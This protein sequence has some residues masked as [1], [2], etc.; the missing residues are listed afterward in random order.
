MARKNKNLVHLRNIMDSYEQFAIDEELNAEAYSMN[1]YVNSNIDPSEAEKKANN[2]YI[3]QLDNGIKGTIP[4]LFAEAVYLLDGRPLR[5]RN[6]DYLKIIYDTDI[7]NMLLMCGRQVEKS[8]TASVHIANDTLLVPFFRTLY[9]APLNEQVKVF[10]EDRLGRLFTY[11]QD[12]VIKRTFLTTHDKQNVFN[13]SFAN[14][15]IV[16][17]RHCYDTG[18]NIRG[19]SNNSVFGDEIQ[20]INVDALPVIGET[21]AHAHDLG[22]GIK[23][24]CYAGTPKT[25]SNTIQ[26]LWDKANQCEWV[27]RCP[28]CNRDQILGL[29]NISPTEYLCRN[30]KCRRVLTSNTIAKCGRWIKFNEKAKSWS[31]RIN[32]LMCPAMPANEIYEKCENYDKQKLY[33]EVLGRSYENADKPFTPMLLAEMCNNNYKLISS[34]QGIFNNRPLFMGIDWGTGE[35]SFTIASVFGYNH[36]GKFQMLFT[37]K[38]D[39]REEFERDY[40]VADISRIMTIFR[41]AYCIADYGHG[42]QSNQQ[43]KARFGERFDCMYYSHSLGRLRIYDQIKKMWVVSRTKTMHEYVKACQELKIIWPGAD[44][45]EFPYKFEHHLAEQ[46]EYR[47]SKPKAGQNVIVTRSEDMYYSHPAGSPDDDVHSGVYAYTASLIKPNGVGGEIVFGGA[48][49][50]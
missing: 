19:L 21:Q 46:T 27:V 44:K 25:Y 6:R 43:L 13:K 41:V 24:T 34:P 17:L 42:F 39:K 20:D 4:S 48:Y 30:D 5:F 22:P 11:S 9:F 8:T 16:Y 40:Q 18:D 10:S 15:S 50:R 38:Y 23:K 49:T 45:E 32:Q 26:Y 3:K 29:D 12:D 33:N 31:F 7:E 37:R 36:E 35:K 1:E 28:H 47:S 14:G 2:V